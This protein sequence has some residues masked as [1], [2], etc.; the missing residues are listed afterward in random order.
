MAHTYTYLNESSVRRTGL[1]N[2]ADFVRLV[3]FIHDYNKL[4]LTPTTYASNATIVARY[5]TIATTLFNAACALSPTGT[6]PIKDKEKQVANDIQGYAQDL[7]ERAETR[8]NTAEAEWRRPVSPPSDAR[9]LEDIDAEL[10]DA[11]STLSDLNRRSIWTTIGIMAAAAVL[12]P[13]VL[14]WFAA[15]IAPS[16]VGTIVL[17]GGG[18]LSIYNYNKN[19]KEDRQ[20]SKKIIKDN[21]KYRARI[22]RARLELQRATTDYTQLVGDG[23]SIVGTFENVS[24]ISNAYETKMQEDIA[25]VEGRILGMESAAQ[26][27]WNTANGLIPADGTV[28]KGEYLARLAEGDEMLTQEN[29]PPSDNSFVDLKKQFE[30]LKTAGVTDIAQYQALEAKAIALQTK[31]ND[32]HLPDLLTAS[33]PHNVT[34]RYNNIVNSLESSRDAFADRHLEV[35]ELERAGVQISGRGARQAFNDASTT[36]RNEHATAD[37]NKADNGTTALDMEKCLERAREAEDNY[38]VALIDAWSDYANDSS[39]GLSARINAIK[40]DAGFEFASDPALLTGYNTCATNLATLKSQIATNNSK[41]ASGT[42]AEKRAHK[43]LKERNLALAEIEI[44]IA[45]AYAM[46]ARS[47]DTTER[48]QIKTRITNLQRIRSDVDSRTKT[49]EQGVLDAKTEISALSTIENTDKAYTVGGVI[50]PGADLEAEL[51]SAQTRIDEATTNDDTALQEMETASPTDYPA[52]GAARGTTHTNLG[53]EC[54]KLDD[55]IKAMKLYNPLFDT[56]TYEASLTNARVQHAKPDPKLKVKDLVTGKEYTESELNAELDN[57]IKNNP[58][59]IGKITQQAKNLRTGAGNKYGSFYEADRTSRDSIIG[60]TDADGLKA[61]VKTAERLLDLY[62]GSFTPPLSYSEIADAKTEIGTV[63]SSDVRYDVRS[64]GMSGF[65]AASKSELETEI[66]NRITSIEPKLQAE[67]AAFNDYN[68]AYKTGSPDCST[69]EGDYTAAHTALQGVQLKAEQLKKLVAWCVANGISISIGG[70]DA[71]QILSDIANP[72]LSHVKK[73]VE[74]NLTAVGGARRVYRYDELTSEMTT[75]RNEIGTDI[76]NL[77]PASDPGRTAAVSAVQAKAKKLEARYEALKNSGEAEST[78]FMM[79]C[80]A[81]IDAA[82]GLGPVVT[83]KMITFLGMSV[84]EDAACD[85]IKNAYEQITVGSN[86]NSLQ[87]EETAF[88]D[89]AGAT[90]DATRTTKITDRKAIT[91]QLDANATTLSQMLADYDANGGD[92]VKLCTKLGIPDKSKIEDAISDAKQMSMPVHIHK[93]ADGSV[94]AV[95]RMHEAFDEVKKDFPPSFTDKTDAS[96]DPSKFDDLEKEVKLAETVISELKAIREEIKRTYGDSDS[97]IA[98]MDSEISGYETTL[99]NSKLTSARPSGEKTYTIE[100]SVITE[101]VL[102]QAIENAYQAIA[103]GSA[104]MNSESSNLS[105]MQTNAANKGVDPYKTAQANRT[106]AVGKINSNIQTLEK[107]LTAFA[108]EP[109]TAVLVTIGGTDVTKGDIETAIK[110]A[111][112]VACGVVEYG[113][114]V[115]L[116]R[117]SGAFDALHAAYTAITFDT[118]DADTDH[119]KW[120]ALKAQVEKASYLKSKME[121]IKNRMVANGEDTSDPKYN[122]SGLTAIPSLPDEPS[123]EKTVEIKLSDG[124]GTVRVTQATLEAEIKSQAEEVDRLTKQAQ[125]LSA[126][127][128]RTPYLKDDVVRGNNAYTEKR[129]DWISCVGEDDS[130]GLKAAKQR[131]E[132]L[133]GVLEDTDSDKGFGVVDKSSAYTDVLTNAEGEITKDYPEKRVVVGETTYDLTEA[134]DELRDVYNEINNDSD[135]LIQN[136]TDA[137]KSY[138]ALASGEDNISVEAGLSE[139]DIEELRKKKLS[140]REE[141]VKS[142]VQALEEKC[143]ELEDLNTAFNAQIGTDDSLRGT[144]PISGDVES[145]IATARNHTKTYYIEHV[146]YIFEEHMTEAELSGIAYEMGEAKTKLENARKEFSEGKGSDEAV[147]Q[148]RAELRKQKEIVESY[149]KALEGKVSSINLTEYKTQVTEAQDLLDSPLVVKSESI[150]VGSTSFTRAEL[151]NAIK[152]HGGALVDATAKAKEEREKV[153]N[154][155]YDAEDEHFKDAWVGVV[156]G[157]DGSSSIEGRVRVLDALISAYEGLDAEFKLANPIVHESFISWEDA[158][159]AAEDEIGKFKE[160]RVFVKKDEKFVS[161]A[162][163]AILAEMT[164]LREDLI[165]EKGLASQMVEEMENSRKGKGS[166]VSSDQKDTLVKDIQEKRAR[167]QLLKDAFDKQNGIYPAEL[168]KDEVQRIIEKAEMFSS[169]LGIED[170]GMISKGE[171]KYINGIKEELLTNSNALLRAKLSGEQE[172]IDD[173]KAKVELGSRLLDHLK[174]GEFIDREEAE[175]CIESANEALNAEVASNVAQEPKTPEQELKELEDAV[176][177]GIVGVSGAYGLDEAI[178]HVELEKRKEELEADTTLSEAEKTTQLT[179]VKKEIADLDE[180][181]KT[182][183]DLKNKLEKDATELVAFAAEHSDMIDALEEGEKIDELLKTARKLAGQDLK[184]RATELVGMSKEDKEKNPSYQA[185][186]VDKDAGA[187]LNTLLKV[188]D[189]IIEAIGEASFVDLEMEITR[190]QLDAKGV[191]DSATLESIKV[192]LTTCTAKVVEQIPGYKERVEDLLTQLKNIGI[193][194]DKNKNHIEAILGKDFYEKHKTKVNEFIV[195]T[196][197]LMSRV[198]LDELEALEKKIKSYTT[199]NDK[200]SNSSE[201]GEKEVSLPSE[202]RNRT[203]TAGKVI[204]TTYDDEGKKFQS[205]TR[206]LDVE[207]AMEMYYARKVLKNQMSQESCLGQELAESTLIMFQMRRRLDREKPDAL[208]REHVR[209]RSEGRAF[210]RAADPAGYHQVGPEGYNERYETAVIPERK[211]EALADVITDKARAIVDDKKSKNALDSGIK[212]EKQVEATRNEIIAE[213]NK[214]LAEQESEKGKDPSERKRIL[215]LSE[216]EVRSRD[217]ITDKKVK[218]KPRIEVRNGSLT[219]KELRILEQVIFEKTAVMSGSTSK[220]VDENWP[221]MG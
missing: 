98:T 62:N 199:V 205:I 80:K 111:K 64:I 162:E 67:D 128:E 29:T 81:Q 49:V 72:A 28:G 97:R 87:A 18:A 3:Q 9:S 198:S 17:G 134:Q 76:T 137:I 180:K 52:K 219:R 56:S 43:A 156:E 109:D 184:K 171:V 2:T 146:G 179:E 207:S 122:L 155:E 115:G 213:F 149:I 89:V 82:S 73:V 169:V 201:D 153:E 138:N 53:D 30:A 86:T 214:R 108:S 105:T 130:K 19:F 140:E 159:N 168:S 220:P 14:G 186:T 92:V 188:K 23:M 161:V 85:S 60:A 99:A 178:R 116:V 203:N 42:D 176:Y 114:G 124:S 25:E 95:Y 70:R 166:P 204:R 102:K 47:T 143:S 8:K 174:E 11:E 50:I 163:S 117:E 195:Q 91:T 200:K 157:K 5:G 139:A 120:G 206:S 216:T 27:A 65:E 78:P 133:L 32:L 22:A 35:E 182:R 96:T 158:K 208:N 212:I 93:N 74:V 21:R 39:T 191:S 165:G 148:A 142:A 51:I 113:H 41:I 79:D 151:V 126:D 33:N 10:T 141:D 84:D 132:Y 12:F 202:I 135:E 215:Y 20:N 68:Y 103:T 48:T 160:K 15:G 118:T 44:S 170:Y 90:D 71:N 88:N 46:L 59:S 31:F 129:A 40:R 119:T 1:S 197:Q 55:L 181:A 54:T 210:D 13:P 167:L 190:I 6:V 110:S 107:Y 100:G 94:K 112:A 177:N 16:V 4:G 152:E 164:Q 189:E 175:K 209:Y 154:T 145:V 172:K 7:I 183:D 196:E 147:E 121:A 75:L 217:G 57:I 63:M 194:L 193:D 24:N 106:T 58:D 192:R 61:K 173:Y 221:P 83:A 104:D 127:L 136:V 211:F 101:S 187:L 144:A 125:G 66:Q 185:I 150:M 123:T 36:H 26:N 69:K 218:A 45:R 38:R 34:D 77:P 131:L 37:G